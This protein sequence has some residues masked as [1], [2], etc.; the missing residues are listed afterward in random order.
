MDERDEM[1]E[2]SFADLLS[3]S[4]SEMG[5]LEPG[6]KLEARV[7]K[8]SAEWVF[9]DTGRK[10]E[11]ILDKRELVDAEGNVTVKEGDLIT[12]YF[13][14]GSGGEMRFTTKIGGPAAQDQLGEAFR[15]GI[16]VEGVVEKEIKGGYQ[17]KVGGTVRAFCPYSQISLRRTEKPEEYIG[18]H[19]KFRI[20]EYAEGGRNVILSHRALLE[21]E[22]LQR[23]EELKSSLKEGM[24]VKGTVLSL[25]KFGAFVDIGGIEALLPISEAAWGRV[26]NLADELSVGQEIEAAI[27]QIDWEKDRITLSKKDVLADPWE[28]V[29]AK[30]PEGSYHTGKVARLAPFGAFVTLGEGIDGLIHISKLGAGRKIAHPREVVKEGDMVE[31]KIEAVDRGSR[32]ISLAMAGAAR[33]A[34]EEAAVMDKFR[35][36]AA[37]APK[38]M[39]TLGDLLKAKLEKQ[40]K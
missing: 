34:D 36:D 33:A 26:E 23:R 14:G 29:V 37:E 11:G 28:S 39:G 8:I 12:A 27:K 30:Y 4:Y 17:V 22:R 13:M 38:G 15:N 19:M 7:L 25:Q 20:A 3:K 24:V 40:K 32:K 21:E 6:A 5:R 35:K 31:V 2:E 9:L 10:G 18:K 1:G 16:P